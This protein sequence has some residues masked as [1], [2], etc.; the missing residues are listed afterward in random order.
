MALQRLVQ[1]VLY[2]AGMLV[3]GWGSLVH[4]GKKH[5]N[6]FIIVVV[7]CVSN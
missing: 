2:L 5:K 4:E 1:A 3:E 6:V 7:K